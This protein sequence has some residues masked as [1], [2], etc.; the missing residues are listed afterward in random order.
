M[1]NAGWWEALRPDPAGVLSKVG[2]ASGMVV[3]DLCSGDG[4]FTLQIAK[5][6]RRDIAI[7]IDPAL[8]EVARLRLSENKVG[9]CEFIAGDAY[10]IARL[11]RASRTSQTQWD[12]PDGI[13]R[14]AKPMEPPKHLAFLKRSAWRSNSTPI[15]GGGEHLPA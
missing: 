6:A 1:P 13:L 4:W 15:E 7:D 8:L 10:D 9:N 14:K 5:L 3:I 11:R 2:I 12:R